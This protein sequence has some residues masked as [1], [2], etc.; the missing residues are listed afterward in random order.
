METLVMVSPSRLAGSDRLM[1]ALSAVTPADAVL[2]P[3]GRLVEDA[4]TDF[5]AR[6]GPEDTTIVFVAG[7][8]LNLDEDYYLLPEDAEQRGGEWR[9]RSLFDWQILQ[10]ELG[11]ALGRRILLIDT[12]HA[13]GAFNARLEKDAADARIVVFS[14]TAANNTAAE[15]R[16]LGHGIF[17]YALLEGLRGKAASGDGVRLLGLADY[18]HREVLRLSDARQEPFYSLL[19]T[20]NFLLAQP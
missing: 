5:L 17:T 1:Q 18:V 20:S 9:T 3:E 15:R 19:E 13:A 2:P 6:P 14:A 8:G 4:L 7:H 16:D 10:E 12:C 11:Y